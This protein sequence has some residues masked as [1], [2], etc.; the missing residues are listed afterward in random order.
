MDFTYGVGCR[1]LAL[2]GVGPEVSWPGL[3]VSY[4]IFGRWASLVDIPRHSLALV[5]P[6]VR[7]CGR[8]DFVCSSI[9][10]HTRVY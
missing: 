5:D 7:P 8:P 4:A 1:A 10:E 6:Q 9:V 3:A 2:F